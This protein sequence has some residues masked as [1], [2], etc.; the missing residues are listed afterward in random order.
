MGVKILHTFQGFFNR[1]MKQNDGCS[2]GEPCPW[3]D[4]FLKWVDVP[5]ELIGNLYTKN[6]SKWENLLKQTEGHS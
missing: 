6:L 1:I 4:L 5:Y 2:C 3:A